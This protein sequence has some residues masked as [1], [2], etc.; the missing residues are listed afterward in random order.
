[1]PKVIRHGEDKRQRKE[2]TQEKWFSGT[3]K[4]KNDD[5][6]ITININLPFTLWG[7]WHAMMYTWGKRQKIRVRLLVYPRYMLTPCTNGYVIKHV[8]VRGAFS[9]RKWRVKVLSL[10]PGG[11]QSHS[12]GD[13]YVRV[14]RP[15]FSASLAPID[16]LFFT[17]AWAHTQKPIFL[18]LI[19]HSKP[20]D[21]P[22]GLTFLLH[23]DSR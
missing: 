22:K 12:G 9:S 21:Q 1:M 17:V 13:A 15:P 8:K 14:K 2:Q 4:K 3:S 20:H 18:H 11:G 19:C 10:A 16:P 23:Q 6:L 7:P 5:Y